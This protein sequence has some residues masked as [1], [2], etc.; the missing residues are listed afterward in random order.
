[1]KKIV[2]DLEQDD[3]VE[4]T[5]SDWEAPSLMVPKK[6]GTYRL[7]VDYRS[8]NKQIEK[9]CWPLP[10]IDNVID[11][12][13]GNMYFSNIDLLSGYFQMALEQKSQNVTTFITPLGHYKR[14]RLP[15][16]LA[17]ASGAFQRLI[18]LIFAGLSYEGALVYLDDVIVFGRN[19]EEYLKR[20]EL[21]FQCL[22]ENGLK[23]KGSNCNF[24][25]KARQLFRTYYI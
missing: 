14:K 24:F 17:S 8:L 25:Q 13:E 9:T 20:L 11:S 19:F 21:V 1:M 22:S 12:L 5:H 2:E 18:E 15:M 10:R 3:L 23:I 6:D 7:V 16:G 4:P